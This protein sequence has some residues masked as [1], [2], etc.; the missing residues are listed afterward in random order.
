MGLREAEINLLFYITS[1]D[2]HPARK[3]ELG[4]SVVSVRGGSVMREK[5][6]KMLM[7]GRGDNEKIGIIIPIL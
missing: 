7:L 4:V 5:I 2:T 3:Q 6:S 1:R